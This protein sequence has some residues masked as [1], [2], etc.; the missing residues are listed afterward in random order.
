MTSLHKK[1][2]I[3]H[4]ELIA[5]YL[6]IKGENSF[7]IAA[8]RKAAQALEND[9]RSM[10][11][12]DDVTKIAGIGKGTAQVILELQKTGESSLL[13]ELQSSIPSSLLQ[14]LKLPG[15]GG[16]KIAKL[17]QEL[18]VVDLESLYKACQSEQVQKLPGF[19]KKTEEK[20][21]K[22][23]E[24]QRVKPERLPLA[25]MLSLSESIERIL[26]TIPSIL[27]VA[28]AGSLRRC[29][30]MVKDLDFVIAT[31]DSKAVSQE[32][33]EKVATHEVVGRG[34]TKMTVL[35][36]DDY[37]VS[38]DFRF[39]TPESFITT[40]HH[41]TGSKEHNVRMRQLAKKRNEKIS[42][43]HVEQEVTRKRLTFDTEEAFFEH[44]DLPYI[45]P[46]MRLGKGEFDFVD[47]EFKPLK[48]NDI[49]ADLHMHTTYSDG[50]FTIEEMATAAQK[51]GYEYICI[52]DHSQSL[53]VANGLSR[54]RLKR[55]RLEID[56]LN[57]HFISKGFKIFA[58]VE[59]DILPDGSLD[60]DNE[61]LKSL[62]FVIAAIHSSFNQSEEKIMHRL[63]QAAMN[64][65]VRLIAHPT[66]RII[67]RRAGY[68]VNIEELMLLSKSTGTALELNSNPN[69]L[70]LSSTWI[71]KAEEMGVKVAINTD[72]HSIKMLDDMSIGVATANKGLIKSSSILNTMTRAE[73]EDFIKS[74]K[75]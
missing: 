28:R 36:T 16:K 67:G 71:R 55:Q 51:K 63:K 75:R 17:Y 11:L 6:E 21:I 48:L 29:E 40:L 39:V 74:S 38:V 58:G 31:H 69:R 62:D 30:E 37:H 66:G 41:F 22:A 15:V 56:R 57:A 42:E 23:I 10:A 2:I 9:D 5:T 27:R 54:E 7:K 19:G 45:P 35:L 32:I 60:Y 14:L 50:A 25:Y 59:M 18:N 46:A 49:R 4:L 26:T 33:L 44:F 8:Y 72:A 12:I 70:D 65:F 68:P 20:L 73:F 53:R 43:Y 47:Q 52:T 61:T 64:P 24:E 34:E 1:A 3:Q 13:R